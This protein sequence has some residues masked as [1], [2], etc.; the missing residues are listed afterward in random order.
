MGNWKANHLITA[1]HPR[2]ISP[3]KKRTRPPARYA[4]GPGS[5]RS[6][7]CRRKPAIAKG[8]PAGPIRCPPGPTGTSLWTAGVPLSREVGGACPSTGCRW[9]RRPVPLYYRRWQGDCNW[10]RTPVYPPRYKPGITRLHTVI[11]AYTSSLPRKRES[12]VARVRPHSRR[13]GTLD[14]RFRGNDASNWSERVAL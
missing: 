9:P 1:E 3:P 7:G 14:S 4:R 12:R 11:P 8:R 5:A 13:R 10:M 6:G 2:R